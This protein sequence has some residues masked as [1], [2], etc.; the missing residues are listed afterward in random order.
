AANTSARANLSMLHL[1]FSRF[2]VFFGTLSETP[3]GQWG[4]V[5]CHCDTSGHTPKEN[6]QFFGRG[7]LGRQFRPTLG[8]VPTEV[9][10]A[11]FL[12]QLA[13]D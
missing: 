4:S 11:Q 13:T 12:R 5:E 2:I 7:G 9:R 8:G 3:S 10:L 1:R 6:L